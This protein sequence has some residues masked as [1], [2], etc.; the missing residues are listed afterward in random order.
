MPKTILITMAESEEHRREQA[1][2]SQDKS[3]VQTAIIKQ[4]VTS[5]PVS[6]V[7]AGCQTSAMQ[8][9]IG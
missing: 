7:A 4:H 1:A 9:A 2:W 5:V 3:I 6:V 8:P